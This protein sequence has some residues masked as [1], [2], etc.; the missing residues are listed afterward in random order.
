MYQGTLYHGAVVRLPAI[1]TAT[2]PIPFELTPKG[3]VAIAEHRLQLCRAC[4]HANARHYE[5]LDEG[6]YCGGT[7][8]GGACDCGRPDN[9][10]PEPDDWYEQ[11]RYGGVL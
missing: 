10:R 11:T 3:I 4:G 1:Y 6:T 9:E 7:G 2:E 5:V 8:F